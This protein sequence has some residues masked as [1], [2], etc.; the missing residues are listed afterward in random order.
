MPK[1]SSYRESLLKSLED[2]IEAV[3][4]LNAGLEDSIE[5]FL[6]ALKNVAQAHQMKRVAEAAGVQR[7]SLYRSLSEQG[8]PTLVTLDAV[9]KAVGLK[10]SI[11]RDVDREPRRLTRTR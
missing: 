11:K 4:Y 5:S 3:A 6:K 10:I 9:L 7:E 2:P 1:T 8:N